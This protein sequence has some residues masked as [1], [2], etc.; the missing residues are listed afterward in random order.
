MAQEIDVN[1][2]LQPKQLQF[3]ELAEY[4]RATVLGVGGSRG[5]AKSWCVR[6]L[7]IY[8]RWKYPQTNGLI[9]RRT[10]PELKKNHIDPILIEHPYLIP[11]FNK[12]DNVITFPN[13]SVIEFFYAEFESDLKRHQGLEY[14]DVFVDEG[15]HLTEDEHKFLRM[16]NRCTRNENIL[17]K[18]FIS[19]NPG[20]PGHD[21]IKRIFVDKKYK[22]DEDPDDY[23]FIQARGWDNVEWV[24]NYLKFAGISVHDYYHKW[25]D[26]QRLN[27]FIKNS[28]YGKVLNSLDDDQRRAYLYGD[29][30]VF[31]GM[32]FQS[33]R[34]D[35]HVVPDV[36]LSP[37]YTSSRLIVAG[38]DYGRRTVLEV[39][40]QDP[41][42]DFIVEMEVYTEKSS[43]S[44][45]ASIIADNLLAHRLYNLTIYFDTNMKINPEHYFGGDKT[46]LQF[47]R[48][49]F[50]ERMGDKAPM[51]IE[52]SK[53]GTQD[54]TFRV[55]ANEMVRELL[56]PR[57]VVVER[58]GEKEEILRPRLRMR[59]R[60]KMLIETLPKLRYDEKKVD[61]MDF[62]RK[63]GIADPFDAMKYAIAPLARPELEQED[64]AKIYHSM[65]EYMKQEVFKEIT[66]EK[67]ERDI[68]A[69][70]L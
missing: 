17:P 11:W 5:G 42:G 60:C 36:P 47:F 53:K 43:P 58:D 67:N 33:F 28:A 24:R 45:R 8:R 64:T 57:K 14:A 4:S 39:V 29:W 25:T 34:H 21:F 26:E 31:A 56:A 37:E 66:G 27:C 61:G 30:D 63:R 69:D 16:S 13:K 65:D 54:N 40:S 7:I 15:T 23:A 48:E 3:W 12:K 1:F 10:A 55:V 22:E 44:E 41:E 2:I 68:D 70:T 19:T 52:A 62:D 6:N 49:V 18:Y 38:L 59:E 20:G 46:P 51:L 9:F 32:F 35:L 50:D